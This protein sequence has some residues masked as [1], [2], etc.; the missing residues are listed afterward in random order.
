[1]YRHTTRRFYCPHCN[2]GISDPKRLR[3]HL[4]INHP[5]AEKPSGKDPIPKR[6]TDKESDSSEDESEDSDD[7][8]SSSDTESDDYGKVIAMPMLPIGAAENDND[9]KSSSKRFVCKVC[10]QGFDREIRLRDHE[11]V[12]EGDKPQPFQCEI[13]KQSFRSERNMRVHKET[14]KRT[15]S[16]S[17]RK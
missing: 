14:H 2:K 8:G 5:G 11:I 16:S 15:R 3:T 4:K 9:D 1:M 7:G 17:K 10:N 13:C 12:H 6:P